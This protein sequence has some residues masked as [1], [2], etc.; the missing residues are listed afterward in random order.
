[1]KGIKL[2]HGLDEPQVL[3]EAPPMP[4]NP[5]IECQ[6]WFTALKAGTP[7]GIAG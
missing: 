5:R 3:V 7:R 1:M 6:T 2:Q 4:R